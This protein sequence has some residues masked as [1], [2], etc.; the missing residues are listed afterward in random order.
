MDDF[1]KMNVNGE[2]KFV[3][4]GGRNWTLIKLKGQKEKIRLYVVVDK[5]S[6]PALFLYDVAKVG[7]SIYKPAYS[8]TIFLYKKDTV[9][10]IYYNNNF[11]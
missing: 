2:I 1:D 3:E 5:Y 4:S 11:E 10:K 8:D 7:D 9:L 6:Q